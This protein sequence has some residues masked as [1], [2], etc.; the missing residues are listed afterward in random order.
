MSG[1]PKDLIVLQ[2]EPPPEESWDSKT[3]LILDYERFGVPV[4]ENLTSFPI[5]LTN[6]SVSPQPLQSRSVTPMKAGLDFIASPRDSFLSAAPKSATVLA[7]SAQPG[8]NTQAPRNVKVTRVMLEPHDPVGQLF[9]VCLLSPQPRKEDP[10][11]EEVLELGFD[12][13]SPDTWVYGQGYALLRNN[14]VTNEPEYTEIPAGKEFLH[15]GVITGWDENNPANLP[16]AGTTELEYVDGSNPGK[17]DFV[18]RSSSK[19]PFK[20]HTQPNTA[21]LQ[22]VS[23][24]FGWKIAVAVAAPRMTLRKPY[25]GILGMSVPTSDWSQMDPPLKKF[26]PTLV[27]E[28]LLNKKTERYYVRLIP[29]CGNPMGKEIYNFVGIHRWPCRGDFPHFS[30]YIPVVPDFRRWVVRLLSIKFVPT[31]GKKIPMLP[32]EKIFVS[33][34]GEAGINVHIDSGTSY[35]WLPGTVKWLEALLPRL[36]YPGGAFSY[37]LGPQVNMEDVS[38][39]FTFK[40]RE[41]ADNVRITC[42]S[43]R[44]L[45]GGHNAGSM[46]PFSYEQRNVPEGYQE[47][48]LRQAGEVSDAGVVIPAILGQS[49][50]Q[51]FISE[52]NF[53]HGGVGEPSVRFVEQ[54]SPGAWTIPAVEV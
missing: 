9:K 15:N 30:G 4:P 10:G 32:E 27:E 29:G 6:D 43:I 49:F 33:T 41:G 2:L 36:N 23:G 35:S 3:R 37:A 18:I 24:S 17:S 40:G 28:R 44:F 20:L 22:E 38:V 45:T 42:S 8:S 25:D 53:P 5:P 1:T 46:S 34:G 54:G 50:L 11:Y 51:C 48:L 16:R 7:G 19:V 12:T 21:G 39:M 31:Q 14:S 26:I 52:F 47:C 13:G